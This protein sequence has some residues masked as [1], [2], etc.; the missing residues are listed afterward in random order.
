ML[1]LSSGIQEEGE[2]KKRG[3]DEI[4]GVGEVHEELKGKMGSGMIRHD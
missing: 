1:F 4:G 3:K 2:K